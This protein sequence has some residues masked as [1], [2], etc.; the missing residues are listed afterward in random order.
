MVRM[1]NCVVTTRAYLDCPFLSD[2]EPT[3]NLSND[4]N[5]TFTFQASNTITSTAD[6][7]SGAVSAYDAGNS[8]TLQP[9]FHAKAGSSFDA[10]I[11]GCWG[12]VIF[13]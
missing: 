12:P 8:I 9:G 13:K 2:C 5:N 4:Q 1:L 10:F 3:Y 11:D 6:I 7:N